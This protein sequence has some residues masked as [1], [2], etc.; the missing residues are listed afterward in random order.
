MSNYKYYKKRH[1]ENLIDKND[2]LEGYEN[3]EEMQK[4]VNEMLH[5]IRDNIVSSKQTELNMTMK[6]GW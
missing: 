6:I 3:E 1:S 4:F 2:L 5:E